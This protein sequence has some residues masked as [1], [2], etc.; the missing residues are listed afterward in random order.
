MYYR[1]KILLSLLAASGGS[2]DKRRLQKLLFLFC[3]KQSKPAYHFVPYKYGC[4]SFQANADL[5]TLA[6]MGMVKEAETSWTFHEMPKDAN[7][8]LPDDRQALSSI[9]NEYSSMESDA[10]IRHTYLAFPFYAINSQLLQKL[11]TGPEIQN[12]KNSVASEDTPVL[13]SLGYEGRSLEE[14]INLLLKNGISRLCDVRKNALSMKYGFSK[15]TLGNAC[16]NVG[17]EYRHYPELGIDSLERSELKTQKDYDALFARYRRTTLKTTVEAQKIL[18]SHI[19]DA[20]RAAVM[21]FE[22][23]P[24]MCHRTHLID[25][26]GRY[27]DAVIPVRNV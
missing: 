9:L 3:Q 5:N 20:K 27:F 12:V 23:D 26:L 8:I 19:R 13:L 2:L 25:S 17:I 16:R 4:F 21:C 15:T 18:C 11:L 6:K 7:T 14:F 22:A 10:L 24:A 1:R